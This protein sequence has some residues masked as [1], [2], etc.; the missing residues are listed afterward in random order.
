MEIT[1]CYGRPTVGV[2]NPNT[3]IHPLLRS[4]WRNLGRSVM[5]RPVMKQ[6]RIVIACT[7]IVLMTSLSRCT[8]SSVQKRHVA[9]ARLRS[10]ANLGRTSQE[11]WFIILV[12]TS[13]KE[14]PAA[15]VRLLVFWKKFN[16]TGTLSQNTIKCTR[17]KRYNR[18]FSSNRRGPMQISCFRLAKNA[19]SCYVS[20]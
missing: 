10:P 6:P 12:I 7:C 15:W 20:I 5:N 16:I 9:I 14:V 18:G 11:V 2:S 19:N 1:A 3:E 4:K 17:N 13:T 8:V